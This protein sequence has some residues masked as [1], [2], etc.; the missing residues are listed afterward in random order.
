MMRIF[1]SDSVWLVT[2][3]VECPSGE[4]RYGNVCD[5]CSHCSDAFVKALKELIRFQVYFADILGRK[6][7]ISSERLSQ[8]G[9][10][11]FTR[12]STDHAQAVP[13]MRRTS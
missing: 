11:P 1:A 2:F 5:S 9:L 12:A 10:V 6:D 4:V 13:W 7:F 8:L 3:L